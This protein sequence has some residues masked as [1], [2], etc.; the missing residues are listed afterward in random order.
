MEYRC[1]IMLDLI[2]GFIVGCGVAGLMKKQA[3]AELGQAQAQLCLVDQ[4]CWL[5]KLFEWFELY[6]ACCV[7]LKSILALVSHDMI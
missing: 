6:I 4:K 7:I 5:V 1:K 3:G 2:L